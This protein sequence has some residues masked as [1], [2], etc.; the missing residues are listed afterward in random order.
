MGDSNSGLRG[1]SPADS[2]DLLALTKSLD[3]RKTHRPE[4]AMTFSYPPSRTISLASS[5]YESALRTSSSAFA[6]VMRLLP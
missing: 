3:E 5:T 1:G 6:P 2:P 4:P